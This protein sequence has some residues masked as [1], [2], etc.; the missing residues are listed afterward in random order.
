MAIVGIVAAFAG[1]GAVE[2]GGWVLGIVVSGV[3]LASRFGGV[4][5]GCVVGA[6]VPFVVVL[7][8]LVVVVAGG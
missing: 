4:G 7:T 2:R 3:F 8:F 5:R 6:F 1:G